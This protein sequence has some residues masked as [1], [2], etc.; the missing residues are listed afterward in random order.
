MTWPEA[1]FSSSQDAE[2]QH[3][4]G[5]FYVWTRKEIEAALPQPAEREFID[6][7]YGVGGEP[8]FEKKYRILTLGEP[9]PDVA[10]KM[11]MSKEE[12]TKRL[13]ELK[14]KMFDVRAQRDKPFLNKIA[15]TAW[16]GHMIAGFAEAGMALGEPKYV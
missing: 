14:R 7:V 3:E 13:D 5:R 1:A 16:S 6:R 4:E 11:K 8:N 2:T 12:F 10:K 9:L 15:L